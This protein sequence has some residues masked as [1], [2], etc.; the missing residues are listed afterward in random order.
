MPCRRRQHH[1]RRRLLQLPRPSCRPCLRR[2][3]H[4][5]CELLRQARRPRGQVLLTRGVL[6]GARRR[7]I[8]PRLHRRRRRRRVCQQ[9]AQHAQHR[10]LP[11]A[12]AR[13]MRWYG[14]PRQGPGN[15]WAALRRLLRAG[16]CTR[17]TL[18]R[19]RLHTAAAFVG[20]WQAAAVAA[21]AWPAGASAVSWEPL[22]AHACSPCC[23]RVALRRCG[24]AARTAGSRPWQQ[25]RQRLQSVRASELLCGRRARFDQRLQQPRCCLDL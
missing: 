18:W 17:L 8:R 11:R 19:H 2:V 3:L 13:R 25:R 5:G 9:R 4:H 21:G 1:R 23:Q 10:S 14:Q 12:G 20:L 7:D 24:T 16:R 6:P 15:G 22:V